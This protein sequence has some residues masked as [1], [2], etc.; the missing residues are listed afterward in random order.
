MLLKIKS[1]KLSASSLLSVVVAAALVSGCQQPSSGD[2]NA[3]SSTS[4]TPPSSSS[5][6]GSGSTTTTTT[7]TV[8]AVQILPK[9]DPTGSFDAAAVPAAGGASVKASRL[10]NLNGSLLTT[11][12]IPTWF[13]EARVFLTSTRTSGANP[14]SPS[15]SDT[16]CAYFD[17]STADNNPDTSGFYTVDGYYSATLSSGGTDIDQCAGTAAAEL[18]KLGMYIKIDRRFMNATDKLQIIVKAKPLDAPNTA[19]TASSCVVGGNFD[20]SACVNQ[21]FT[22][23]LRTAPFAATKPFYI[24]FPSAKS[25]DLLSESVL[26]PISIDTSI[27]TISIDRVKGGAIFYGLTVIR[28]Q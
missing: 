27:T 15:G 25:L 6:S 4:S 18:N 14:A 2:G 12:L 13:S 11:S 24:L 19:P 8:N 9:A 22:L 17:T 26:L 23:S 5:S 10:Y 28:I 7:S 20:A 1:L 16:P 21:L 3:S